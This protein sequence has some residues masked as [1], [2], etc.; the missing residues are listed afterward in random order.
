MMSNRNVLSKTTFKII[1]RRRKMYQVK[2]QLKYKYLRN[3][4]TGS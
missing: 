4:T 2:K 1:K 3:L